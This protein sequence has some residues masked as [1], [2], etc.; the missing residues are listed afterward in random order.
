[1]WFQLILLSVKFFYIL[2]Q[3]GRR[4]ALLYRHKCRMRNFG[5]EKQLKFSTKKCFKRLRH[6]HCYIFGNKVTMKRK[7][8]RQENSFLFVPIKCKCML[9]PCEH[10][11]IWFIEHCF[12]EMQQSIERNC[13]SGNQTLKKKLGLKANT[14][15]QKKYFSTY[16]LKIKPI[17]FQTVSKKCSIYHLHFPVIYN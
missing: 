15:E 1:M 11:H 6:V 8:K 14:C 9:F 16:I 4:H 5:K 2:L 17:L 12:P 13:S 3:K 10:H 7:E